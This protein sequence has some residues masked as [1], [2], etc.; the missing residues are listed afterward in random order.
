VALRLR[1]AGK[2]LR[3]EAAS[4]APTNKL[5]PAGLGVVAAHAKWF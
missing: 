4:G 3:L 2:S 5:A 1:P